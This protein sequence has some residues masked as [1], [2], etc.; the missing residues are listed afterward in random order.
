MSEIPVPYLPYDKLRQL[1]K[2]FLN[3]HHPSGGIPI[4]VEEIVEFKLGLDIVP[5]PGLQETLEDDEAMGFTSSDLKEIWVDEWIWRNRPARYRFT[6][7]HEVG[8]V[9]LHSALYRRA[10]FR[11]ID[12]WKRFVRMMPDRDHRLY[13]WQAYSFAGLILVPDEALRERVDFHF[14]AISK[15]MMKRSISFEDRREFVWDLIYE[16]A[17]K[18]FEVSKDVVLRRVDYDRLKEAFGQGLLRD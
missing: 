11:S 13:E 14:R 8:H 16:R 9:V 1:A 6:L 2:Q 7:A 10:A 5:A 18:D 17:A 3:A 12:E 15:V 4:P